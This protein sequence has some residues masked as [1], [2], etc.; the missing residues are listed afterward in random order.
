V[1]CSIPL[2]STMATKWSFHDAALSMDSWELFQAHSCIT[3]KYTHTVCFPYAT[4]VLTH[5]Q[6]RTKFCRRFIVN[7]SRVSHTCQC[8]VLPCLELNLRTLYLHSDRVFLLG[9]T[10]HPWHPT[11]K[12]IELMQQTRHIQRSKI[13]SAERKLYNEP[14]STLYVRAYVRVCVSP[15][16]TIESNDE[17]IQN[18]RNE[19]GTKHH[20][21]QQARNDAFTVNLTTKGAKHVLLILHTYTHKTHAY[22]HRGART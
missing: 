6:F 7:A 22:T 13:R 9:V 12:I 21:T 8:C 14:S 3:L 11:A 1:C 17:N 18:W 10:V 5:K 4:P 20:N 19:L 2:I 15:K 16:R